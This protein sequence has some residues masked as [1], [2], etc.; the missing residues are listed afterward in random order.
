MADPYQTLV[1]ARGASE[2]DIKKAYRRLARELHPDINP[3]PATQEKFKEVTAAYEVLSD[4]E[5]RQMF[6]LG[7]DPSDDLIINSGGA[8]MTI[9]HTG[10]GS[11]TMKINDLVLPFT[12]V[13][14]NTLY[15]ENTPN[16]TLTFGDSATAITVTDHTD[17]GQTQIAGTGF[18]TT[19]IMN[20]AQSLTIN[21]GATDSTLTFT[22]MDPAFNPAN[23][24]TINGGTGANAISIASLGT[25]FN[26]ELAVTGNGGADSVTITGNLNLASL[27]LQVETTTLSGVSVT[28]SGGGISI[29][30]DVVLN[31]GAVSFNTSG[32]NLA[33]CIV[34]GRVAGGNAAAEQPLD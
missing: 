8:D 32:G 10:P 16:L 26:Q 20:P 21:L 24:I 6:D 25:A 4:P 27:N 9:T 28:T 22:S 2:A 31:T 29:G 1:V 13:G 23:G 18:T 14:N 19:Q 12:G 34:F 33:E 7:G 15:I 17:V 5:K 30:G 11:G 3:D